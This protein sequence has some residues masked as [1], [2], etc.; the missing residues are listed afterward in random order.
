METGGVRRL[1][2]SSPSCL[3]TPAQRTDFFHG[4]V[5][6]ADS[7]CGRRPRSEGP[8]RAAANGR[9]AAR[10]WS[11]GS[12]HE[13]RDLVVEA[14]RAAGDDG[15]ADDA[16]H[17][18]AASKSKRNLRAHGHDNPAGEQQ[19]SVT[20]KRGSR[21]PAHGSMLVVPRA[22]GNGIG[23]TRPSRSIAGVR[24]K[25]CP[26]AFHQRGIG[27]RPSVPRCRR[28]TMAAATHWGCGRPTR[29][30]YSS[31]RRR[32]PCTPLTISSERSYQALGVDPGAVHAEHEPEAFDHR[33][34]ERVGRRVVRV[35]E[36]F[37]HP[38]QDCRSLLFENAFQAAT[39]KMQPLR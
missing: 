29:S 31:A 14:L 32:I 25:R 35:P 39:A 7:A 30:R 24:R 38:L 10:P 20:A 6:E 8:M 33:S 18:R 37:E 21:L 17:A 16:E 1:N 28:P 12:W 2:R 22:R 19:G 15:Q 9:W 36:R 11:R 27:R 4:L 26:Q 13:Q 3:N 5:G 34:P 23:R